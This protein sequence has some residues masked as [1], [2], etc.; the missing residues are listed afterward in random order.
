MKISL[1]Q[2]RVL[3]LQGRV[4]AVPTETVYGLAA[5]VKNPKAIR[6]T[7]SL[8]KRPADNPLIVHISQLSQLKNLV[9][10][11]PL[12]FQKLKKFCQDP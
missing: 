11:I 1:A 2:A 10:S 12:H 4:V 9:R 6:E 7:F 3:M 8:K 5:L